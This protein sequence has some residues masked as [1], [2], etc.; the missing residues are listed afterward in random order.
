MESNGGIVVIVMEDLLCNMNKNNNW[1]SN[2][3]VL[4]NKKKY[5]YFLNVLDLAHY[6]W[7]LGMCSIKKFYFA[8]V[9][10]KNYQNYKPK[11]DVLLK[12]S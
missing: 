1:T 5:P 6:K 7:Y 12:T 9:I 2:K 3:V 11:Y 4:K 8:Y 10:W